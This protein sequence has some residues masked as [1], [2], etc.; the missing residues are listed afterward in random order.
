MS[1]NEKFCIQNWY[2]LRA[3]NSKEFHENREM[4]EHYHN[5]VCPYC[6]KKF[7]EPYFAK[8]HIE[9]EH[10]NSPFVCEICGKGFHS[11]Q[12]LKYHRNVSHSDSRSSHKFVLEF[13]NFAWAPKILGIQ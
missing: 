11:D 6:N 5:S 1:F 4:E 10:G 13:W 3:K 8:K 2:K 12:G 7:C 9:F